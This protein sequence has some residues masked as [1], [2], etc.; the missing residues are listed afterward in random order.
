MQYTLAQAALDAS[1]ETV[2]HLFNRTQEEPV[3]P[4][5]IHHHIGGDYLLLA[6]T[7]DGH[8]A[9][10]GC[11]AQYPGIEQGR[12][13]L[14]IVVAPEYRGQGIGTALLSS[15][16]AQ[17]RAT[18]AASLYAEIRDDDTAGLAY[19]ENHGFHRMM[20]VYQSRLD[21][22]AFDGTPFAG[23]IESLQAEGFRFFRLKGE[24]SESHDRKAYE[25]AKETHADIPGG[26]ESQPPFET[27]RRMVLDSDWFPPAGILVADDTTRPDIDR[28]AGITILE[29]MPDGKAIYNRF[30]GT[31]RAYRGRKVG[32]ALKLLAVEAARE[33]GGT[34][35]FTDNNDINQPIVA[36]NR[37]LG[38]V[39]SVGHYVIS[40]SL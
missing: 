36:M 29:V 31:A 20:Q 8:A 16:E 34:Y 28:F 6:R 39:P 23:L 26:A 5:Q 25:T 35:L 38:Y 4:A 3:A 1:R 7:A 30:T 17:A 12:Q 2:T 32:L 14:T 18:G 13:K 15:L 33:L 27:W 40:K 21:L 37:K 10:F 9:A 11:V 22:G 19:C 24:R